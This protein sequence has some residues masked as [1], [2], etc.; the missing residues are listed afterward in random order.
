VKCASCER[1]LVCAECGQAFVPPN[2]SV[3]RAMH[4]A[5]SAIACPACEAP[6]VCR[7]CGYAYSGETQPPRDA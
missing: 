1:P 4:E 2:E 7:W 3:Y 6:L 5:E